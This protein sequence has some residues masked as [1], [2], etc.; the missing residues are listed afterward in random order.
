MCVCER[1]RE[2]EKRREQ[3]DGTIFPKKANSDRD[4]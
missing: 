2:I 4:K 3:T 1:E